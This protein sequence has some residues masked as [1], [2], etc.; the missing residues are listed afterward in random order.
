MSVQDLI[1]SLLTDFDVE[2]ESSQSLVR[3][4]A[5]KQVAR[6]RDWASKG[7]ISPPSKAT[8]T[9]VG[10]FDPPKHI[11]VKPIH[12]LHSIGRIT[13][14]PIQN[15]ASLSSTWA[16]IR[17]CWAFA[18]HSVGSLSSLIL[19]PT[20]RDLDFHQKMLLSDEVGVGM[21]WYIM[22]NYF[23]TTSAID[24]SVALRTPS[25]NMFEQ[26][27][28]TPDYLFYDD[29][30]KTTWIFRSFRATHSGLIEPPLRKN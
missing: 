18:G 25:W 2:V 21:A 17:Y 8:I 12:L 29:P 9:P 13:T 11:N 23:K 27:S 1:T 3:D 6:D 26:Y 19:S 30:L 15:L 4:I 7:K 16:I 10:L 5:R 24:V 28:A 22:T 20:A 14:P